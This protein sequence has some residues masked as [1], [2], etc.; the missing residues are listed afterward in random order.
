MALLLRVVIFIATMK[1]LT[2]EP[3]SSSTAEPLTKQTRQELRAELVAS[4]HGPKSCVA[5]VLQVLQRR[6]V[7]NDSELGQADERRQLTNASH[8]HANASTPYG[9]VVQSIPL[10]KDDGSEFSWPI[11]HPLAFI[12]YWSSKCGDFGVLLEK[13]LATKHWRL[14]LAAALRR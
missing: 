13:A 9:T 6:G 4:S 2:S 11:I 3:S 7:L 5:N 1:R 12:W 10:P 8:A 14:P